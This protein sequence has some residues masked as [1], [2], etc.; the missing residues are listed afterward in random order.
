MLK[1]KYCFAVCSLALGV[2][3]G[4]NGCTGVASQPTHQATGS[5]GTVAAFL[6]DA[7]ADG[8]VAFTIQV[9]G[10]SLVGSNGVSTS[11]S[12]GVQDIEMRHLQ[13]A[14][15][16]A[17]Q[18]S[19]VPTGYFTAFNI[20]F[21]NPQI[22]LAD[23]QGHVTVLNSS[24]MP[25]VRL[26]NFSVSRPINLALPSAGSASLAI[27]FDLHQSLQRDTNGNYVVT[28]NVNVNVVTNSASNQNIENAEATVVSVPSPNSANLQLRD[29]GQVV[30][31]VTNTSTL[32]ADNTGQST[33]IE[34]GQDV[35]VNAQMQ[36]DGSF[37]ATRVDSVS[38]NPQMCFSGVVAGIIQDSLGA[39]SV[40][41]VVQE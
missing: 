28:P 29:T 11:I 41:V 9:T 23:A 14:Q 25:S 2:I 10:A 38:S 24:T 3:L 19:G 30:S 7:P 12:R 20:S 1:T 15:T 27:D 4:L 26:T 34:A 33:S 17:F 8:V 22:T 18:S 31:V 36:S 32:F 21:A 16:L 13:L 5:T 35:E 40:E 6:T 37:I 39:S